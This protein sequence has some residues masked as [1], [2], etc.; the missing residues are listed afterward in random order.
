MGQD[1]SIAEL[2]SLI[3]EIVGFHGRI[4]YDASK[5]DGMPRKL[6]DVSRLNGLGWQAQISLRAG[7]ERTW[8]WYR[9]QQP[10][11]A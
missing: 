4:E 9:A 6:L 5:P 2:A 10:L 3:A 7:I 11:S 1:I 8:Q